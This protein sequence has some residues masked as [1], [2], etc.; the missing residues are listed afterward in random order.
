[1]TEFFIVLFFIAA[2]WHFY[3]GM[4]AKELAMSVGRIACRRND[5]QFL[6]ETAHQVRFSISRNDKGRWCAWRKFVFEYTENG[7]ERL[8]GEVTILGGRVIHVYLAGVNTTLH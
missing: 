5:L 8:N 7:E 1:M 3:L 4:K 6:D 2:S